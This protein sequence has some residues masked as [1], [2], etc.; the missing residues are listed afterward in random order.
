MPKMEQCKHHNSF[1]KYIQMLR[2]N[3]YN[4]TTWTHEEV[5]NLVLG[6]YHCT[7]ILSEPITVQT[8]CDPS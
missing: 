4:H 8:K 6:I 5:L 3:K 2:E 7:P 1:K